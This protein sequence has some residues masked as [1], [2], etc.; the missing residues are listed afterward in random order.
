ME[1]KTI[2]GR[3][4]TLHS[5]PATRQD[6]WVIERTRELRGGRF[7]ECGINDGLR[8]SNTLALE[9]S[10]GWNGWLV[11]ADPELSAIAQKNRPAC[12]HACGALSVVDS[13]TSRFTRGGQWGGLTAFLPE[14][15]RREHEARK[16]QDIWVPTVT[17]KTFLSFY[18]VPPL[19]DYLSLDIEGAE[20]PVLDEFFRHGP[21]CTF[22]LLTV[23]YREDAGELMRLQRILEPHG[24]VLD[25]VRAW[26]AFFYYESLMETD[27]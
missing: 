11:E 10:F 14:A 9:Q 13:H 18:D 15:W 12:R 27:R 21:T 6:E 19:I 8:H 2:C 17:L 20:V 3:T 25:Q 26:D 1:T 23:E 16:A 5:Q 7:I 24:Y 4:T 22:R